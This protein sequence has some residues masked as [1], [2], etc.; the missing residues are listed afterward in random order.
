M[1]D[2]CSNNGGLPYTGDQWQNSLENCGKSV[3]KLIQ[4]LTGQKCS[5]NAT[6]IG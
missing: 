3:Q 5:E 1:V 2:E 6:S 4:K